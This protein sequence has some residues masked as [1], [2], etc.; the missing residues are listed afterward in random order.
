VGLIE[1]TFNASKSL[2][3]GTSNGAL[4]VDVNLSNDAEGEATQLKLF[5]NI[6][7]VTVYSFLPRSFAA[8][9]YDVAH[10]F[11]RGN[12]TLT[13]A[14]DGA[15]PKF[16]IHA[17]TSTSPLALDV[18]EAPLGANIT[19]RGSSSFGPVDVSLPTTFEGV[20]DAATSLSTVSVT[21]DEEAEDPAGESRKR[22]GEYERVGGTTRGTIGWSEEGKTRGLVSV[23]TSVAPVTLRF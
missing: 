21:F 5:N 11:I 10:R 23:R 13:S 19:L 9:T 20:F 6:A 3:L 14:K 4:N 12:I 18:L 17:R 8:N 16:D 7:C 2:T 1:G 15:A 22:R